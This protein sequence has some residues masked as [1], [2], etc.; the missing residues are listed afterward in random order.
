VPL[1]ETSAGLR[2]AADIASSPGV[3]AMMF[4]GGDLSAE[5]GVALEWEPLLAA[6]GQFVLACAGRGIGLIDVP[7]VALDDLLGLEREATKARALGFTAKAAIH[8]DQLPAIRRAFAPSREEVAEAREALAAFRAGGGQAVR[9]RGRLLE[10]P[11]VRRYEAMLQQG[12][13]AN[14]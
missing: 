12:E 10:A 6:R 8:P 5:L 3:T 13:A 9:Y 4:G 11:L 14:A 1:I 2:A 7:F